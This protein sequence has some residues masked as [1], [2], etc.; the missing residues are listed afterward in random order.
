[1]YSLLFVTTCD[2]S[3]LAVLSTDRLVP[4]CENS[5]TVAPTSNGL[6]QCDGPVGKSGTP[7]WGSK[8]VHV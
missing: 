8:Q 3:L 6:A 7:W 4:T 5:L 2:A 1:M